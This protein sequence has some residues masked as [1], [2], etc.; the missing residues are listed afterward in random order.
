[1]NA[2]DCWRAMVVRLIREGRPEDSLVLLADKYGVT[3]PRL[4][5]GTVKAHRS[6]AGCYVAKQKTIY[7]SKAEVMSEP[8]VILHEFYHHLRSTQGKYAASE[9]HAQAFAMDFMKQ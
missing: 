9:K 8:Y 1:M 6:V 7:I 5:V 3:P 4:K 2:D